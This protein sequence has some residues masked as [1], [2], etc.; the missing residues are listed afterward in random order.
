MR[1]DH[2]TKAQLEDIRQG[3]AD[4]LER[5]LPKATE[6]EREAIVDFMVQGFCI[7]TA[8]RLYAMHK[9]IQARHFVQASIHYVDPALVPFPTE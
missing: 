2:V 7:G 3:L 9:P 8:Y 1:L 5:Q 4:H 6:H